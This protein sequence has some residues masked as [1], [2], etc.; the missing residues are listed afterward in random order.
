M[1]EKNTAAVR[2]YR[3]KHP[4]RVLD[5]RTRG[6]K[7][8]R[9]AWAAECLARKRKRQAEN[10][11]AEWWYCSATVARTRARA[12]V[13]PYNLEI[14]APCCVLPDV[15]PILGI[16][17]DYGPKDRVGPAPSSPSLDRIRPELGYVVGNVRVIS[18]RAN[19]IRSNATAAELRLVYQDAVN[20]EAA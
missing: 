20:L 2:R 19:Q 13:L 17:L 12:R 3:K 10:P 8:N 15:C 14:H 4:D 5:S 11:K 7:K 16:V 6:R 18:H 1:S 9:A